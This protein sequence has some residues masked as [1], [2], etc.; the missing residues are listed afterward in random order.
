MARSPSARGLCIQGELNMRYFIFM[1]GRRV[2]ASFG[3]IR[4]NLVPAHY[5]MWSL[6]MYFIELKEK[7]W[8]EMT[9]MT[10][11]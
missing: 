10:D 9:A 3:L 5:F 4:I 11:I 1:V 7:I 8:A 2:L 6:G